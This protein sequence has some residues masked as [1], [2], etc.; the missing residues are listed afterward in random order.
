MLEM[1]TSRGLEV[2]KELVERILASSHLSKSARLTE[3]FQYLC[4]RVL[5]DDVQDI[6]ELE[7]GH[8]VFGRPSRYDTT[9]DNIV[10]VH[11][12][13]LRKRLSEYFLTEGREEEFQVEIPR[14]N[15]APV[16]RRRD[17]PAPELELPSLD[18]AA[19]TAGLEAELLRMAAERT[20][21]ASGTPHRRWTRWVFPCLTAAFAVLSA[22]LLVR[23]E[24]AKSVAVAPVPL[25]SGMLGKFWAGIFRENESVDVVLDDASLSFYEEATGQSV[26]IADY[27][28]RSYLRSLSLGPHVAQNDPDWLHQLIIK[29]QSNYADAAMV[30]K[31]AQ[32]ASALHSDAHLQFAR[33]LSFRQAKSEDLILLGTPASDPWIQLFERNLT[34]RWKYDSAAKAFYP[35]DTT[36]PADTERYHGVEDVKTR[37]GYATIS[38]LPNLGG[39]GN[40]LIVSG[41]GGAATDATMD[42]MLEEVSMKLLRS[43]LSGT[44][45]GSFP[46]FEVLLKIEKGVDRPRNVTISVCREF[47]SPGA[48]P[49]RP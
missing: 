37:E 48:A 8:K 42:W 17:L 36:T 24:R 5:D 33:D 26:A 16:F 10:R 39:T 45:N 49:S 44:A 27:F 12:S 4:A 43:R 2:H 6:H 23:L 28:D 3:L 34:L 30:W 7:L 1:P 47:K 20:P 32:T 29:R 31:L 25:A 35:V 14:G 19:T 18:Q 9:A 38:F 41:T 21:S 46:Y 40:V 13:L 11:A 15:Y 22:V